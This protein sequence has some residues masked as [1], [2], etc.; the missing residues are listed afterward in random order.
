M[1]VS[2]VTQKTSNEAEQRYTWKINK[3]QNDHKRNCINL[4]NLY[5]LK[6]NI[7]KQIQFFLLSHIV[8]TFYEMEKRNKMLLLLLQC[9]FFCVVKQFDEI[10]WHIEKRIG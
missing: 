6:W 3:F 9:H 5:G 2:I 10:V 7:I 1:N 8:S 4:T